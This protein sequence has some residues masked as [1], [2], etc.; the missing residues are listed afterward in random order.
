MKKLMI[1]FGLC[2]LAAMGA[3]A[4]NLFDAGARNRSHFGVKVAWDLTSPA[5]N[6]YKEAL[7]YSNGS[8]FS[9]GAY[10][11]MPLYKNLYFEPGLSYYYNTVVINY[12]I[13]EAKVLG[14]PLPPEG[15]LRNSGFRVPLSVGYRFDFTDDISLAV[16]TGPQLNLGVTLKQYDKVLKTKKSLY[17][18]GWRRFDAQWLFG[19][20]F[21][22]ADNWFAEISGGVGMTNLLGGSQHGKNYFRRNTFSVS[23]GYQF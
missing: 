20:R 10:Y 17:D 8:G 13:A 18:D 7:P 6:L 16:F 19:V 15:S 14:Y 1:A 21:H 3:S 22:Y 9:A 5:T 2:C 23:V 11:Q 4:Q 12:N